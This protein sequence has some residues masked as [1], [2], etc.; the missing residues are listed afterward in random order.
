VC[1]DLHDI[2]TRDDVTTLCTEFYERAF[3]DEL[4]GPVFIDVAQLDLA[5]HMP[6]IVDFWET[7]L[8]GARAYRGGAFAPHAQLHAKVPL[9]RRHFDRWL[10]IWFATVD[11]L[12]AGEVAEDAKFRAS[13]VADA[14]HARLE[15]PDLDQQ[16]FYAPSRP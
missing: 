15:Q 4:L 10:A 12:F 13:R 11:R 7:V 1:P 6:T 3:A 2:R 5:S 9:T 16:Y 14:F 8:L